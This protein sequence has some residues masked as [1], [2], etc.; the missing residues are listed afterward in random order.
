MKRQRN[1]NQM[2][3]LEKPPEKELS[4]LEISSMHEKDFI[5]MIRE[6]VKDLGKNWRQRLIT[7]NFYQRNRFKD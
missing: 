7:R 6:M 5:V 4:E 1:I 3:E 2:R